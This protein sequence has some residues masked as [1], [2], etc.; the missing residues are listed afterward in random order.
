MEDLIWRQQPSLAGQL[1]DPR[2]LDA[3]VVKILQHKAEAHE[4]PPGP[5][6]SSRLGLGL[7]FPRCLISV[8]V[9]S[10]STSY[11][12]LCKEPTGYGTRS[13]PHHPLAHLQ[14]PQHP[15]ALSTV[16]RSL[17]SQESPR[18]MAGWPGPP[19]LDLILI[20]K[21]PLSE[22]YKDKALLERGFTIVTTETTVE[23]KSARPKSWP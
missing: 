6:A 18:H 1:V 10:P 3:D 22:L 23:G 5:P 7:A 11:P 17:A 19:H 14:S 15:S 9:S 12:Q 16:G 2:V 20:Y 4:S 13:I 8:L 21:A